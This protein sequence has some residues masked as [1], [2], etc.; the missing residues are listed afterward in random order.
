METSCPK[1]FLH[2]LYST[3][4]AAA[5]GRKI[6]IEGAYVTSDKK[7]DSLVVIKAKGTKPA[8]IQIKEVYM[9]G[10]AQ[11]SILCVNYILELQ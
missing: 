7:S 10:N 4:P 1:V 3:N 6:L 8:N 9:L 5:G 2:C 11:P